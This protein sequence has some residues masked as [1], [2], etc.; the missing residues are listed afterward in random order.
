MTTPS[1]VELKPGFR[2]FICAPC[3]A[4]GYWVQSNQWN[5]RTS[6]RMRHIMDSYVHATLSGSGYVTTDCILC[7]EKREREEKAAKKK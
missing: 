5:N 3:I 6:E 4:E 7:E 1:P 2:M